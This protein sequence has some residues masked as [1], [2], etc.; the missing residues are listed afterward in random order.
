MTR[1]D[2]ARRGASL[3]KRIALKEREL[4]MRR[5]STMEHAARLQRRLHAAMTGPVALLAAA[6]LGVMVEQVMRRR[7]DSLLA[8]ITALSGGRA[9]LPLLAAAVHHDPDRGAHA[10]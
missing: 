5:Q 3:R 2:A 9:L 10:P 8:M 6:G 7:G 1:V 4:L